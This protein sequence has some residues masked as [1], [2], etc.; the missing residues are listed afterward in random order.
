MNPFCLYFQVLLVFPGEHS[1]TIEE[2]AQQYREAHSANSHSAALTNSAPR[3]P[4]DSHVRSTAEELPAKA[5]SDGGGPSLPTSQTTS[6]KRP[7]SDVESESPSVKRLKPDSTD[8]PEHSSTGEPVDS[9]PRSLP[10]ERVVFI[11][12]T[13][14][15]TKKIFC[16]ERLKGDFE[17]ITVKSLI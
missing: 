1:V 11:D 10:Y 14:N 12:S 5:A 2:L 3:C 16:D 13:W 4:N 7:V 15:Q 6:C 8:A 17:E 9:A